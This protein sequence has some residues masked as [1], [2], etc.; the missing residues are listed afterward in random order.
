MRL[1]SSPATTGSTKN[2]RAAAAPG[3]GRARRRGPACRS[4]GGAHGRSPA[5]ASCRRASSQRRFSRMRST[6]RSRAARACSGA[7]APRMACFGA[8]LQPRWR[9]APT[10]GSWAW[11]PRAPAARRKAAG[12]GIAG[13]RGVVPG[14]AVRGQVAGQAV[15]AHLLLGPREELDQLPGRLPVGRGAEDHQARAA[16]QRQ[17]RDAV[18]VGRGQ[19]RGGPGVLQLGRQ[20]A[21]ELAEVPGSGDVHGEGARARTP[22]RGWRSRCWPPAGPGRRGRGRG[23]RRRRGGTRAPRRRRA[24]RRRPAAASPPAGRGSPAGSTR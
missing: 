15:E 5:G 1:S 17:A 12:L 8:L 2:T 13:E 16:G 10:R 23:R 21:A 7:A 19:R 9:S 14:L 11:A 22:G 3:S 4:Q 18:V 6:S 24:C 20:P